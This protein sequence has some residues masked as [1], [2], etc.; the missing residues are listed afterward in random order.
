M[1]AEV[2][3]PFTR[4]DLLLAFRATRADLSAWVAQ[5]AWDAHRQLTTLAQQRL[6][7]SLRDYQEGIQPVVEN[8]MSASFSLVG[9]LPNA[10]EWGCEPYDMRTTLLHG[11]NAQVVPRGQP[12]IHEG[13][14]GRYRSI[15]FRHYTPGSSGYE[16]SVMGMP[17]EQM[18]GPD[19]ARKLGQ[20]VYNTMRAR[21]AAAKA[22][23]SARTVRLPASAGGP[24]LRP[25]HTTG[26]Y[27]GM[28]RPER[29]YKGTTQGF[30]QTFRTISDGNPVGWMHPVI[31]PQ[32]LMMDTV[33]YLEQTAGATLVEIMTAGDA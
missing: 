27:T 10:V 18:L 1:S 8:G 20:Q 14:K 16:G 17:Y 31:E 11:P 25:H 13:K 26:I 5:V 12:G 2:E 7:T 33:S 19:A 28:V 29:A 24:L 4:E 32:G 30:Y 23:G 15:P 22:S 3:A 21:V 6:K 9:W